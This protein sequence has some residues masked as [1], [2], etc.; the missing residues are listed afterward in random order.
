MEE[1]EKCYKILSKNLKGR[2][3]VGGVSPAVKIILK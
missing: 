1:I 3:H 2:G